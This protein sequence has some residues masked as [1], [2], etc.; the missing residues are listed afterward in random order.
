MALDASG[1][2]GAVRVELRSEI[3]ESI[4]NECSEEDQEDFALRL[5]EMPDE[6][7]F[8]VSEGEPTEVSNER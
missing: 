7:L 1:D 8:I 5:W 2:A 4:E 6:E 3:F